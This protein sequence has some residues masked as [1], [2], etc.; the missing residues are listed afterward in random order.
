MNKIMIGEE[1]KKYTLKNYEAFCKDALIMPPFEDD[2][3]IEKWF[4][5]HKIHIIAN[6]C[7]MELEYDAD[8]I[9]EIEFSLKEIHTAILGDGTP[10][11][12]N[13]VGSEYRDATWKDILRFVALQY[14]YE[15]LSMKAIIQ[16]CI[17]NFSF[18]K[19][20][21]N[22][23][24]QTLL[25]NE[26]KVNFLKL[27]TK[28]LWKIFSDKERKKAFKEILCTDIRIEELYDKDGRCADKVVITDYS[29]NPA[30]DLVGWHYG[31]DF[32]KDS[33]DNQDYIQTYI[34][35]MTK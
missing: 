35:E 32:D 16:K 34:K 7:D 29:I 18:Q 26:L 9:N 27:D 11:T 14:L 6:D 3:Q 33:E 30:G 24:E 22:I 21:Q 31:V 1:L 10:T 15:G 20:M 2:E 28:D 5:T 25:N 13:T 17:Y 12:G 19:T 23:D 4:D 8:I